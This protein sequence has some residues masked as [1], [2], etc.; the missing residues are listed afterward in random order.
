MGGGCEGPAGDVPFG[1]VSAIQVVQYLPR[2]IEQIN[3]SDLSVPQILT[4]RV[5]CRR[6]GVF[7]MSKDILISATELSGRR[8]ESITIPV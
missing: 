4:L 3:C 2:M 1:S 8:S 6:W 5:H 7:T